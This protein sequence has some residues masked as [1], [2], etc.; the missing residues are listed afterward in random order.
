LKPILI[1]HIAKDISRGYSLEIERLRKHIATIRVFGLP[2]EIKKKRWFR[3]SKKSLAIEPYLNGN[4]DNILVI[5]DIH[6]PLH[7]LLI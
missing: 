1:I 4:T 6:A 3:Q 5:G 2:K 7:Y